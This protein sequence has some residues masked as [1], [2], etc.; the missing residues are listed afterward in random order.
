[1]LKSF[2][3]SAAPSPHAASSAY[4]TV[5]SAADNA[6]ATFPAPVAK[7]VPIADATSAVSWP[8]FMKIAKDLVAGTHPPVHT[9]IKNPHENKPEVDFIIDFNASRVLSKGR[10]DK[11]YSNPKAFMEKEKSTKGDND[12]NSSWEARTHVAIHVGENQLDNSVDLE[13]S[14]VF[15]KEIR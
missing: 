10:P 13:N 3:S 8:K 1:M 2:V 12:M 4:S 9:A 5:T 15:F 6:L 11:I 14:K 7:E